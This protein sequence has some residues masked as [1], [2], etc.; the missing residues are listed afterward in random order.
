MPA[1]KSSNVVLQA[2]YTRSFGIHLPALIGNRGALRAGLFVVCEKKLAP[3]VPRLPLLSKAEG[4][5]D[6]LSLEG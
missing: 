2:F 6:V 4:S 5:K 3:V 1:L